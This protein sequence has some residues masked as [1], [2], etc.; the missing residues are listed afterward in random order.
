MRKIPFIFL[1]IIFF[2]PTLRAKDKL[3][4][5]Q[6]PNIIFILTDDQPYDYLGVTGN[7]YLKTPNIDKLANEG[8]LMTNAHVVSPI[9]MPS[10]T[11]ILLSQYERTHHVDFN[12]GTAVS[13]KAWANA[14]PMVLRK[15]GYFTG[16]IGKNHTPVG[17]GAYISGV[18]EKSFDYFMAGHRHLGFYPKDRHKIFNDCKADT[19]VEIL[20]EV[21]KDF[22]ESNEFR[23]NRATNFIKERPKEKPF[24]LNICFNLP[25]GAST[26][27]MKMKPTDPATY[28]TLYRDIDIELDSLYVARKDIVSPKL[29]KDVLRSENRQKGYYYS[30]NPSDCKERYIRQLQACTGIDQLVGQVRDMLKKEHLD[31]NTIIVYMSDHGLFMGQQGLY[32]KALLY[33]RCT[34]IPLIIYNPADKIGRKDHRN[35]ALVESIDLGTTFLSWAGITAPSTYQGKDISQ[36]YKD[37]SLSVRDHSYTENLWSTQ[38][39]NPRCESVQNKEWKYIRY[40]KNENFGAQKK[41]QIMD[42][43]HIKE[44]DM[45]YAVHEGDIA[46]YYDYLTAS[47]SEPAVYEELYHISKD[48]AEVDNLVHDKRYAKVLDELRQVWKQKVHQAYKED[49]TNVVP[50]TYKTT[51]RV[52][53]AKYSYLKQD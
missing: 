24:F 4:K 33:E 19:Q 7:P 13:E 47:F 2:S 44:T 29:P 11:S 48:R 42:K 21:S 49:Y 22:L 10:R 28:R 50:W 27:T 8:V 40:Y 32:G 15:N 20:E 41:Y 30:D 26:S 3:K 52:K 1:L 16:Y 37:K 18:L 46:T 31:K 53:D 5:K 34:R 9:C 12:S 17:D 6:R 51:Q 38:F 23:L 45:L 43:F 39:G 14:Y 35:D 36:V 25:H